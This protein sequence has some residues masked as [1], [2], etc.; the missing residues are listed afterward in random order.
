MI[1]VISFRWYFSKFSLIFVMIFVMIFVGFSLGFF[2]SFRWHFLSDFRYNFAL[3]F[4]VEIFP[5]HLCTAGLVVS[6]Y[7]F[8]DFSKRAEISIKK[9]E[10]FSLFHSFQTLKHFKSCKSLQRSL[11]KTKSLISKFYWSKHREKR[12]HSKTYLQHHGRN[13]CF[14]KLP[15]VRMAA[16]QQHIVSW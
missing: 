5:F 16:L 7:P 1:F 4:F 2:K 11:Q 10:Y 12:T 15:L 8:S 14:I 9:R 6:L 13:E 3:F